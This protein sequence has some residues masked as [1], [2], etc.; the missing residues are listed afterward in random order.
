MA[1][2]NLQNVFLNTSRREKIEVTVFLVNG[3][4]IKGKV[5]SF[6]GFTVL[7]DSMGKQ[8]LIYKH[9]IS[10]I[11]PTVNIKFASEAAAAAAVEIVAGADD[12]AARAEDSASE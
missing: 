7:I 8:N 6:D 5:L 4:Q 1:S 9:A 3:F 2:I 11:I 10:T 12:D